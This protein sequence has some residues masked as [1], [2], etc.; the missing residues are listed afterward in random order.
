MAPA[1]EVCPNCGADVPRGASCCPGCGSDAKTGWS[2]EVSSSS[3]AIP[4]S[5]FDY[6]DYVRRE[7]GGP[8]PRPRGISWFWWMIA[9][10]LVVLSLF[11][12]L[13]W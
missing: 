6:N 3:P 13:R 12:L 2:D 10:V 7:F 11:A 1:P 5:D 8:D 4:D 9:C